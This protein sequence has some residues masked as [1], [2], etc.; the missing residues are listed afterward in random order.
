MRT[1]IEKSP[2]VHELLRADDNYSAAGVSRGVQMV[3]DTLNSYNDTR[4]ML[5]QARNSL[6][7]SLAK[8]YELYHALLLLPA[9][10]T[11]EE[12]ARQ[13]ANRNKY[14]PTAEDLNP[15]TRLVDNLYVAAVSQ[16]PGMAAFTKKTPISWENDYFMVKDLLDK[17]LA[18]DIYRDYMAAETTDFAADCEFW[19]QVMK[20][21][22]L[23]SD[24]LAEALEAKSVYWNDD[25][26]IM[27]T[28]VLKTMRQMASAGQGR[29]MPLLPMYKD[30]EDAAFGQSLFTKAI[31]NR[32]LYRSYIDRFINSEQWDS[33]RLAFMDIVVMIAAITELVNFPGIPL[34][35]TLNEYI[36]IANCYSTPRSGQFINGIL[37]SVINYLKQE[38]IINKD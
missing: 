13:D 2:I 26:Q 33:E 17:I 5:I 11:R 14:L 16:D 32:D 10:I 22:I 30:E 28:F 3:I 36:E 18:S 21:I 35:V 23:P 7:A 37:Y 29:E 8:A 34:A 15:D 25:L 38:G 1:I 31:D 19:R 24:S 27:G 6:D 4:S 9:E 20:E 12:A